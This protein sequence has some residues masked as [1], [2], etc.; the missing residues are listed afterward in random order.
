[1]HTFARYLFSSI[2]P[3]DTSL[4]YKVG[5]RAMR[6]SVLEENEDPSEGINV[7]AVLSRYPRWFTMGHI[8]GQQCELAATMLSAAKGRLVFVYCFRRLEKL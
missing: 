8:E 7:G 2:L 4:A 5:L 6:L 1:M 3:Y